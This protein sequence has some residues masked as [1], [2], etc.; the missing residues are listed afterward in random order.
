VLDEITSLR[1]AQLGSL[2]EANFGKN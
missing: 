1:D 2:G